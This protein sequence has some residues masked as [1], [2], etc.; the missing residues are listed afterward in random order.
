MAIFRVYVKN[1]CDRAK[2]ESL[3]AQN[4][5]SVAQVWRMQQVMQTQSDVIRLGWDYQARAHVASHS[6]PRDQ[7]LYVMR[8]G[9]YVQTPHGN[10]L[11]PPDCALWIPAGCQ[12]SVD[13]L[14][15]AQMRSVYIRPGVVTSRHS[16]PRVLAVNDLAR[17]LILE[18][19]LAEKR[20]D[21]D[22]RDRLLETLLLQEIERLPEE[23]LALP[24][25][26]NPRLVALC[27]RF[28][29]A[30]AV[31]LALDDWAAQAGMSRRT[32][33]RHF[34]AQT[35]LSLDRWRQRACVLC[36]LQLL[37]SGQG[38]TR[39]ALELGYESPAAFSTM[40]RRHL[41]QSPREYLR[42]LRGTR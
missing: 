42:Q 6:H 15:P 29:E 10:W 8:G 37:I 36:S 12:H 40:F 14:G 34:Q 1:F 31:H 28:L 9:M 38:V 24:L 5:V 21:A 39:V 35:G 4:A 11:L 20:G 19:T 32:L 23:P 7:L 26:R 41:G 13:V 17:A 22:P 2:M 33:S 27:Q 3:P 16:V 30:P 18:G 25:P